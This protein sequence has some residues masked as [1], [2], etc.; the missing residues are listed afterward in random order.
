METPDLS[1]F[2]PAMVIV[3]TAAGGEHDG[4][5]VGF[6]SQASIDPL[7]LCVW[8]SRA[9]RT[10]ALARDATHLGVHRLQDTPAHRTLAAHFGE[11]TGDDV[12]KLAGLA[13]TDGPGGVPLL[14]DVA[15]RVVV[16]IEHVTDAGGD[17]VA[18]VGPVA[19]H[20]GFDAEADPDPAPPL[21]LAAVDDL[22]P[23]HE[24]DDPP[25]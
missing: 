6:H 18:F 2:D 14:D 24:A 20:H 9:N 25:R 16:R 1:R 15:D 12:D 13:T 3:T 8:L 4:C 11:Q 21:R 22:D 10:F 23:G 7:H 19:A 17:H 5:L